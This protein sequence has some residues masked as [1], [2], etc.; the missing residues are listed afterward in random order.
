VG[1]DPVVNIQ[2]VGYPRGTRFGVKEAI[3]PGVVEWSPS[4][5]RHLPM[6]KCGWVKGRGN[7]GGRKNPH[8]SSNLR[9]I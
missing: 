8:L 5:A 2:G 4:A 6:G 1:K 3:P 7:G 9:K